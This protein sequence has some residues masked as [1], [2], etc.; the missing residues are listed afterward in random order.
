MSLRTFV[1]IL[2]AIIGITVISCNARM[3]F[4]SA[5]KEP[6]KQYIEEASITVTAPVLEKKTLNEE[7]IRET[8][9]DFVDY[10]AVYGTFYKKV[11]YSLIYTLYKNEINLEDAQ[12]NIFVIFEGKSFKYEILQNPEDKD[13]KI[14]I[15]GTFEIDGKPF[16]TEIV[17]I[18][19][20][21][22]FWQALS[23]FPYSQ[24][25]KESAQK[26]IDSIVIDEVIAHKAEK[27]K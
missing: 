2:V 16:G 27:K 1:W 15:S 17:L 5:K 6:Q 18:K 4:N 12:K 10:A 19:R 20:N 24:A 8:Q 9:K 21:L 25:N 3:Q 23:V 7:Q 26:Y 11:E 22:N 14:G 13:E